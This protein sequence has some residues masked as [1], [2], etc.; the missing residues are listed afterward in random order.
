MTILCALVWKVGYVHEVK[1]LTMN[2]PTLNGTFPT[3][4]F[5]IYVACDSVYFAEFGHSFVNSV[6]RH[7]QIAIHVHLFN[8]TSEQLDFCQRNSLSVTWETIA[9]DSFELATRRWSNVPLE[10]LE[11]SQ[12][13]RTLNAMQK[14]ND[15]S[16]LHRMQK[17]YYACARFIRLAEIV[18]NQTVL[19]IDIDAIVRCKIPPLS[20]QHDF[21]LHYI[22]GKKSRYLA[23]GLWLNDTQPS[24]NFL[25]EYSKQLREYFE[26]D[27]VYWGLDQDLLDPIVPKFN[28]G[29][30]PIEYIDWNMKPNS[31]I[32]TAKGTRK[33]SSVF[34]NEQ[35]KYTA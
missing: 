18:K 21:Y 13:E 8:P 19:A 12:H 14:G 10:Q 4:S 6:R 33:E 25:Q 2:L 30:L 24:R 11:K 29:Q 7:N 23:G 5:F 3:D 15:Y 26:K 20:C 17:T 1:Y 35:K 28:H 31:Y 9:P 16:I 32:W 34:I 27:Y 22:S